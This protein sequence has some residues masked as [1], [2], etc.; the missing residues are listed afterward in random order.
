MLSITTLKQADEKLKAARKT[1]SAFTDF[2]S[3]IAPKTDIDLLESIASELHDV[4]VLIN[5]ATAE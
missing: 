2:Q 5:K 4:N 3:L 1:L